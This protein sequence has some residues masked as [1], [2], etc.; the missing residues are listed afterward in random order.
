[1]NI[2]VTAGGKT[3]RFSATL[4]LPAGASTSNPVPVVINIGGM[5]TQP[6][7]Q[8]GIAIVGFDYT[9]VASDSNAKPGAFFD[10]SSGRDIGTPPL[11]PPPPPPFFFSFSRE[12]TSQNQLTSSDNK[13]KAP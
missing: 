3:G 10:T 13:K 5:S 8:A 7:L 11:P 12:Q 4:S 1:M 6:Y 9:R 2:E